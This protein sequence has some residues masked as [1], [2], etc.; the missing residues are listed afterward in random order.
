MTI[1]ICIAA[2][3]VVSLLLYRPASPGFGNISSITS[4]FN[5]GFCL[6][7][8]LRALPKQDSYKNALIV[9]PSGSGKTSTVLIGTLNALARGNS[10]FVILDVSGEIY[11][12]LNGY[13]SKKNKVYCI[14]FSE[15]SDG[16]NP[17]DCASLSDIQKTARLLIKN[18]KMDSNDPY[19]SNS[20][21]DLIA[22][23]IQY[24]VEYTP[25]EYRTMANLVRMIEVFAGEP[26]KVDRCFSKVTGDLLQAYKAVIAVGDKTLHSTVSTALI[27]LKLFKNPAVARCSAKTTVDFENFRKEKSVL[28]INTPISDLGF[29]APYSALVFE[30]LFKV[31]LSRIPKKDEC[32]IF[33]ILDEMVTMRFENLGLVYSNIRKYK[34]GCI[35]FVQHERMLE[36][37]WSNA[38]AHAIRT[39][40]FSKVYLPGQPHATCKML[41]DI[42]GKDEHG[43]PY[44]TASQIRTSE[45]AVIIVGNQ[46]P[47]LEKMIPYFNHWLLNSRT[48][49]PPHEKTRNIPFDTPPI[50]EF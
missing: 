15:T 20:A 3:L 5:Q 12:L 42:I 24:L 19:W 28:F 47:Y 11:T 21:E 1:A 4:V 39:N 23:F 16:F 14:D 50:L 13:L 37:A 41:E 43:K 6:T 27:S 49:Y 2:I 32:S 44:M 40:S 45:S 7:G 25:T 26:E 33:A 9:G 17:L 31:V 34:G 48:K 10:S 22:I 29:L 8:G 36:M 38:E 30:Q 35:G 18:A 46:K